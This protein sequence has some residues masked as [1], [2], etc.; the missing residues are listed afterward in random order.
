LLPRQSLLLA[1]PHVGLP[2]FVL[3]HFVCLT[4]FTS[5]CHT[6]FSPFC[7]TLHFLPITT[8]PGHWTLTYQRHLPPQ[9]PQHPAHREKA[10]F[11]EFVTAFFFRLFALDRTV[12]MSGYCCCVLPFLFTSPSYCGHLQRTEALSAA[13]ALAA[14]EGL[15]TMVVMISLEFRALASSLFQQVDRA[16][17]S[18]RAHAGAGAR[19]CAGMPA[20][21][22]AHACARAR[23][24][25]HAC[26]RLLADAV[27]C[28][29]RLMSRCAGVMSHCAGV[30]AASAPG[31][32]RGESGRQGRREGGEQDGGL[33]VVC[34]D[35]VASHSFVPCGHRCVCEACGEQLMQASSLCPTCREKAVM[36]MRVFSAGFDDRE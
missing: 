23:A 29:Q 2:Y 1:L 9:H 8:S 4:S 3:P 11:R 35:R 18:A 14:G 19:A 12:R 28:V 7:F 25:A 34:L 10:C 16:I 6:S 13:A 22:Y 30:L 5:F 32:A 24:C 33:C 17:V 21:A 27:A 26:A 20:H 31:Y 36:V 15:S